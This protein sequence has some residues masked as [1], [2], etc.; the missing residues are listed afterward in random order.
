MDASGHKPWIR[1]AILVGVVYFVVG[2]GFAALA[3]PSGSDQ[4]RWWRLAA[5]VASAVV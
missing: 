5:W 3:N 2:A 1:V 4:V